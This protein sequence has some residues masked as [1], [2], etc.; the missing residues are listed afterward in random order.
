V[1]SLSKLFIPNPT[2]LPYDDFMTQA[3]PLIA[4][5]AVGVW[6]YKSKASSQ[7]KRWKCDR[8]GDTWTADSPVP[9]NF[10]SAQEG[11]HVCPSCGTYAY[12][13]P[14]KKPYKKK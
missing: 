14:I 3:L 7:N 10:K 4:V 5:V 8:C 13:N 6:I 12:T 9:E 2:Q 11:P 1:P